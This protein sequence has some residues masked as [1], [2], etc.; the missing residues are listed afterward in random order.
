MSYGSLGSSTLLRLRR[1]DDQPAREFYGDSRVYMDMV[2]KGVTVSR[3][4][5]TDSVRVVSLGKAQQDTVFVDP[6]GRKWQLR[7]WP[8]AFNDN[9]LVSLALPVPDGYV[10]LTR[11][12]ASRHLHSH[13]I[14]MQALTGF[15]SVMYDGSFAQWRDFLDNA[16]LLPA[17]FSGIS[18]DVD[19]GHSFHYKS[20]RC[21]VSFTTRL[22]PINPG[23]ELM[24]EFSFFKDHGKTVWDVAGLEVDEDL[25]S[26]TGFAVGRNLRP[27][28]SMSDADKSWWGKI[29]G[30]RHPFDAIA[31]NDSDKTYIRSA[32]TVGVS[33]SSADSEVIYSAVYEVDGPAGQDVMKAKL[34]NLLQGLSVEEK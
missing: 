5:G 13:V 7:V 27:A 6:Y 17:A 8:L 25:Q 12:M 26:S 15:V 20:A 23:S 28:D 9:Y 22:Q 24:L 31:Y 14:D 29:E 3:K 11:M 1:P 10:A 4:L 16:A 2:L 30:R 18:I 33:A 32:P 19:Y 21:D 34:D